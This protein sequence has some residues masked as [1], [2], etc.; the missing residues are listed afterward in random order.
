MAGL[1]VVALLAA[2]LPG[3]AGRRLS[4]GLLMRPQTDPRVVY[5]LESQY[6]YIAVR[7][8]YNQPNMRS[9]HLDQLK[10]SEVD[11]D[12]PLSLIYEYEWVYS[13][14]LDSHTPPGRPIRAF[15]IGGGGFAFPRYLELSRPGSHIEAAEIDPEVTE[16]AHAAFGLP[17]DTTILAFNLDARN[18]I[19]DLLRRERPRPP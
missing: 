17:R 4:Q 2:F 14:V 13:A 19:V 11:L 18:H 9:L 5:E 10:H 1:C 6:S 3:A 15:V 16:A 7:E 12:N 8:E